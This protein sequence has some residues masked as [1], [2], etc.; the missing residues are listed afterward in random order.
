MWFDPAKRVGVILMANGAWR[1]DRAR[2]LLAS[3]FEE[4]NG[5][6]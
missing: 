4:A 1:G 2:A 6:Q 5:V 3:L